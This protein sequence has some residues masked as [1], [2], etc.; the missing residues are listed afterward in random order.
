MDHPAALISIAFSKLCHSEC[1]PTTLIFTNGAYEEPK[2]QAGLV[3]RNTPLIPSRPTYVHALPKLRLRTRISLA[4][5]YNLPSLGHPSEYSYVRQG[6][7]GTDIDA[8][9]TDDRHLTTSVGGN[10]WRSEPVSKNPLRTVSSG[11]TLDTRRR[12][13]HPTGASFDYRGSELNSCHAD[14]N[15]L[16]GRNWANALHGAQIIGLS[17]FRLID[18]L[19]WQY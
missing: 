4:I 13:T 17:P 15:H 6:Q 1:L 2:P 19:F 12:I 18:T 9:S 10:F 11:T 3:Y 7:V 8:V 16:Y 5:T 14:G